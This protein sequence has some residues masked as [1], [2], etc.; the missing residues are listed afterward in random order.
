MSSI[1]NSE[2]QGFMASKEAFAA[3]KSAK[4]LWQSFRKNNLNPFEPLVTLRAN[5]FNQ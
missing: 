1:E 3:A 2:N 5:D 4:V